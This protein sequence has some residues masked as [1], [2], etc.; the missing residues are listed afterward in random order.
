M[1]SRGRLA[2]LALVL[3][4]D[5]EDERT[6]TTTPTTLGD[7]G[8]TES[9][10]GGG[11][12]ESMGSEVETT[13]STS[14]SDDAGPTTCSSDEECSEGEFCLVDTCTPQTWDDCPAGAEVS[15]SVAYRDA[16]ASEPELELVY[17]GCV[18]ADGWATEETV[19]I[20]FYVR[21]ELDAHASHLTVGMPAGVWANNPL[22]VVEG[23]PAA[24]SWYEDNPAIPVEFR[25]LY[26]RAS[27]DLTRVEYDTVGNW[28]VVGITFEGT[29]TS[30]LP[31]T[32]KQVDLV[33][34]AHLSID[35]G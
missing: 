11:E 15:V 16:D 13:E 17:D 34:E 23:E 33:I 19:L 24:I 14:S 27:G 29:L 6:S 9:E 10:S 12:S 4:C 28:V 5:A 30:Y 26:D 8:S 20:D 18:G 2:L 7:G 35:I 32:S 22:E 3:A 21:Q 31:D 1:P 25:R